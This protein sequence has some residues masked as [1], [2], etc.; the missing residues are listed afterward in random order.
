MI[1]PAVKIVRPAPQFDAIVIGASAGGVD[2]LGGLLDALPSQLSCAVLVV[3]HLL[4]DRNTLL[5]QLFARRCARP[6]KEAED[7]E[8]IAA[9]TVYLAPPDYHLL[10]EPDHTLALSKDEPVHYSRPAIDPLFEAAALAYR[11]R[12]LGI[13]LTGA[14]CDGAQGLQQIRS[15]GGAT[16]VQ[17]PQQAS[18]SAMPAAALAQGGVDAVLTLAEIAERLARLG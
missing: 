14:S 10:V 15:C 8:P 17:D 12:L 13:I 3:L 11:E 7:K 16:W 6:V 4:P 18:A 2:A 9:G 1:K 5:P